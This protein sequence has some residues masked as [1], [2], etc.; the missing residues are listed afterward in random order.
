MNGGWCCS[1]PHKPARCTDVPVLLLRNVVQLT[2]NFNAQVS[3]P[4]DLPCVDNFDDSSSRCRFVH[5][6]HNIRKLSLN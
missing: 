5:K 1:I 6:Q 2:L 3:S 4:P